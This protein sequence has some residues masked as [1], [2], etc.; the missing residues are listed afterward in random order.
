MKVIEGFSNYYVT[1]EG[2]VFRRSQ[3]II[4]KQNMYS[5]PVVRNISQKEIGQ[6]KSTGYMTAT[7]KNDDGYYKEIGIH[8]LVAK[9]FIP[10]PKNKCCI[11][12]KDSDAL[13]NNVNNLEWVTAAENNQHAH[14][15]GGKRF[16][17]KK[18]EAFGKVFNSL[19]ECAE[20]Y[21]VGPSAILKRIKNN[22]NFKYYGN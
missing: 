2:K 15:F 12:H 19:K 11:N 21:D 10:N 18:I 22:K 20:Y 14:D 7:M 3:E 6:M 4:V 17:K 8:R 9:A 16:E 1:K 5:E 13:N